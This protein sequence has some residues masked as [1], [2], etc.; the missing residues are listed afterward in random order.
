MIWKN[1]VNYMNILD[2]TK[3]YEKKI[4]LSTQLGGFY[5]QHR[6][7][8]PYV[9]SL[10]KKLHKCGG[11][12]LDSF[13]ERTFC[14][15]PE[16]P[17]PHQQP[18]IGFIHVPPNV[19]K[20]FQYEQSNDYIFNTPY[21]QES[22]PLCRGL[23]TLSRWHK[24]S[25]EKKLDIPINHL[26]FPTEIPRL[27][28]NAKKFTANR[29]KKII[30][31]G[32]WLR[33]LHTIF[34]LPTQKYKKIFLKVTHADLDSLMK[35]E[36]EILIREGQF[37]E[38]MYETVQQVVY[39]PH[40]HYDKLLSENLVIINLYDSSANNTV[41]ECIARNTPLLVNPIE[42]VIEYLGKDYPFY[43]S[44][45]EEAAHK[46]EDFHLVY[47]THQYLFNHSIK[48]KL[49][50]DYFLESFVNSEIYQCL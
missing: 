29:E 28:W 13:I 50:G 22:F 6:S 11:I 23:F 37:D 19:P 2:R 15:H 43:F 18:W 9:L 1:L 4:D 42:P 5:G 39:V 7:G 40:S 36:R 41:I 45:L 35:K 16:G 20:W 8:W 12:L 47:Q 30:Q 10:L 3:R 31:V 48:E 24:K 34:Q 26:I 33:K 27:K 21:W 17:R 49:K 25:L 46:A 38:K 32:W 44:S 14:W